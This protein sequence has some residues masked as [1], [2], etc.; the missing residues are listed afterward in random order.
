M[1][2]YKIRF[3]TISDMDAIMTF[4]YTHWK[5]GHILATNKSFF[6]YEYVYGNDVNFAIA[7]DVTNNDIVG[8]C[9]FIK[10]SFELKG[11]T[12]WG[13]VWK[14]IK[15]DNPML[16]V[17]ILEFINN[18]SGCKSFSSCGI[19]PKTIPIYKFLRFNTGQLNHYYQLNDKVSY[20]VAVV[21]KKS[22]ISPNN[23]T[24]F[25]LQLFEDFES[26]ST[27]F[28]LPESANELSNK[29]NWYIEKRYF[30]HPKYTYKVF[31]IVK[32]SVNSILIAREIIQNEVKILRIVDFIG[33]VNDINFV[34]IAIQNLIKENDYEYVD[35]YCHGI[36]N[37]IMESAGF[38]LRDENDTN[39]IPNYFEPFVQEN[40][41][42]HFFTTS[43]ANAFVFKADGDQD[44]PST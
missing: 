34:G 18:N 37:S 9:G 29:D 2:N 28:H 26:L 27:N 15:T 5:K 22:F 31:G 12:I 42:I 3:A 7:T 35:F 21:N 33:N 4:I 36:E 40:I 11:A 17:T 30:N 23:S 20:E 38:K 6:E 14:V 13:S 44:R 32:E 10:N 19:A 39:I 24:Q 8:L 16:G 25:S 41:P 43:N 1:S